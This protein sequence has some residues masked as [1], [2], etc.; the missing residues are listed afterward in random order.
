MYSFQSI[1]I[2]SFLFVYFMLIELTK[3]NAKT[4]VNFFLNLYFVC[5]THLID[6]YFWISIDI[7]SLQVSHE[8]VG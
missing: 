4:D 3:S 7:K 1:H 5:S 8:Y 6:K 2:I